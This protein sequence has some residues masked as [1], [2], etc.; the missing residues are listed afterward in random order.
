MK[1]IIDVA[2]KIGTPSALTQAQGEII[3]NLIL[4]S[5][6]QNEKVILDFSNV[7]S[8][9]TP[10]LNKSIGRLYENYTSE[11]IKEYLSLVNFPPAKIKTLNLVIANAKKYYADKEN[12][13]IA[14]KEVIGNG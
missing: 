6:K 12:Y 14:M 4:F 3:H 2:E 7:E 10:F 1:K 9:I 11:Y 5:F 8:M 13:N